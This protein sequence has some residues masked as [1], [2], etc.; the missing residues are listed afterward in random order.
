MRSER[1]AS[2]ARFVT[3]LQ[4][5]AG[6]THS[7]Q[8][9]ERT[10]DDSANRRLVIPE[11]FLA[12]DAVML[13]MASVASGLEVHRD[14]IR[15]RVMDELPFMATEAL[16]MRGVQAGGDRQT[17]HE[18]V[19]QHSVSVNEA[20]KNGGG[21]NDL[22]ERLDADAQFPATLAEMRALAEPSRFHGRA[23]EQVDE[24]LAEVVDPVLASATA[25]DPALSEVPRV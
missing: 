25:P 6:E 2:L 5:N 16:L 1:I 13:L 19:R 10:L 17:L 21:A 20:M 23:P 24:F 7:V 14:M 11:A 18:I 22:L 3:S 9:F 4:V 8:Y 15:R 12:T